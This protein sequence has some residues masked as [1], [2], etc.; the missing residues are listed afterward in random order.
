[1][2][3]DLAVMHPEA[4]AQLKADA[5]VSVLAWAKDKPQ[6]HGNA[7]RFLAAIGSEKALPDMRDWAFP[8]KE[9]PK[10]GQQ[11]PFPSE[12]ETAQSALRYLGK[13]K[14]EPSFTKLTDEFKRKKDKK[15][16]ITQAGLEG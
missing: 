7:L 11:P 4:K 3:A 10:E 15:L 13:M 14:D 8:K 6:P 5:E 2:L 16:D 12:Y 9:P 1:M